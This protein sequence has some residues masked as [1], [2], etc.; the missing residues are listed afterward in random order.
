MELHYHSTDGPTRQRSLPR[1]EEKALAEQGEDYVSTE[2]YNLLMEIRQCAAE[3]YYVHP[4]LIR[5]NSLIWIWVQMK[6]KMIQ[7]NIR[8]LMAK[9]NIPSVN[10]LARKM[11]MNPSF[12]GRLISL[13]GSV[14][15]CGWNTDNILR[16]ARILNAVP[17][18]MMTADLSKSVSAEVTNWQI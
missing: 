8:I 16:L 10:Q 5:L 11:K 15:Y 6:P 18:L 17:E 12:I 9:Q 4:Q 1:E 3:D 7:S 2:L 14:G 13:E